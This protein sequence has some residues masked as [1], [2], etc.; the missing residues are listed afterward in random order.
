MAIESPTV[1][2]LTTAADTTTGRIPFRVRVGV[3][4]HRL[5]PHED[6]LLPRVDEAFARIRK[7]APSS[8]YTPV[9]VG[10]VSPLAEG[11]DRL[12]ARAAILD[13]DATW[14]CRYRSPWTNIGAISR[15]N[16]R[17][18]SSTSCSRKRGSSRSFRKPTCALRPT[19]RWGST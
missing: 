11:A 10:V 3:T 15:P 13:D 14:R 9:R 8:P 5:L 12:V 1:K 19:S 16:S 2:V 6:E 4:G 18:R 7:Q 17:S